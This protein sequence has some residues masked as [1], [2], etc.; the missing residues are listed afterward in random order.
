VF[1]WTDRQEK[2]RLNAKQAE[3]GQWIAIWDRIGGRFRF[4]K[5]SLRRDYAEQNSCESE[6]EIKEKCGELLGP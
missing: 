5:L 4:P 3:F 2:Q 1:F 6:K